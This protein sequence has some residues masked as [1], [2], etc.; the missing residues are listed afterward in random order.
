MTKWFFESV[1]GNGIEAFRKL[2][3]REGKNCSV[4]SL[5]FFFSSTAPNS[6]ILS[7]NKISVYLLM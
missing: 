2:G 3:V 7:D 5:I 4:I 1:L 6:G